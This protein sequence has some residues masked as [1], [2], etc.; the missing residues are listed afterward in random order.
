MHGASERVAG[1]AFRDAL[2]WIT[3]FRRPTS[4]AY[5]V[6]RAAQVGPALQGLVRGGSD[7]Q[8]IVMIHSR[9]V[10][11]VGL[12]RRCAASAAIALSTGACA[13]ATASPG[14]ES[15]GV[16]AEPLTT[17]VPSVAGVPGSYVQEGFADPMTA[18]TLGELSRGGGSYSRTVCGSVC[19][20]E[21]GTYAAMPNNPAIGFASIVFEP[22]SGAVSAYQIQG[23][24]QS[25]SG[26]FA[27][28]Q[29]QR[30]LLDGGAGPSFELEAIGSTSPVLG[31]DGGLDGSLPGF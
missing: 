22:S 18:M 6:L 4:L 25:A 14:H 31:G 13:S 9:G 24:Q 16:T 28:I 26:A 5:I 29:L 1:V 20:V 3:R 15:V 11:V 8:E 23:V 12:V 19:D 21:E 30:L 7:G 2:A 27:T 10:I 17:P